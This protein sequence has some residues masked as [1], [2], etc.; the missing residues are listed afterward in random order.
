[1]P[2][3]CI[4]ICLPVPMLFHHASGKEIRPFPSRFRISV[5]LPH[6]LFTRTRAVSWLTS[7]LPFLPVMPNLLYL[8][9]KVLTAEHSSV[10][11]SLARDYE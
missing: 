9:Y 6:D 1:M 5:L 10:A 7:A 8:L 3:I 4:Y 2:Y 11:S